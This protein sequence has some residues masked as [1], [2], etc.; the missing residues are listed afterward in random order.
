MAASAAATQAVAAAP[1]ETRKYR[2]LRMTVAR[3][4][5]YLLSGNERRTTAEAAA[6]VESV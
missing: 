2:W 6:G 3:A 1:C 4:E 5:A